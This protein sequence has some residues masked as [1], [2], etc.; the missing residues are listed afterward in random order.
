MLSARSCLAFSSSLDGW[1]SYS[2]LSASN[3]DN[4]GAM[5]VNS[6]CWDFAVRVSR[7]FA[8]E[9][10]P[11]G[12]EICFGNGQAAKVDSSS[13]AKSTCSSFHSSVDKR[14]SRCFNHHSSVAGLILHFAASFL[15]LGKSPHP[16]PHSPEKSCNATFPVFGRD[17][18]SPTL[19]RS[20]SDEAGQRW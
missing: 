12:K 9:S 17:K 5:L 10:L 6:L 11:P 8:K 14:S 2:S 19:S 1:R 15:R 7:F 20:S 13:T 16:S 4:A 3:E 18:S